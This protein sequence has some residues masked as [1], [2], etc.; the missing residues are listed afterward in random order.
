[1]HAEFFDD[2][3]ERMEILIMDAFCRIRKG[4]PKIDVLSKLGLSEKEYDDNVKRVLPYS[5]N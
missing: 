1:M 4:E 2:P 5:T 3:Q